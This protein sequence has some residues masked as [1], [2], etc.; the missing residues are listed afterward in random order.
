[1]DAFGVLAQLGLPGAVIAG[2]AAW[3]VRLQSRIDAEHRERLADQ[4]T[5]LEQLAAVNEARLQDAKEF[6]ERA[7]AVQEAVHDSVAKLGE[8]INMTMSKRG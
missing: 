5:F 4:R 7:L 6:G 2:L 1:M 8:L 3:C